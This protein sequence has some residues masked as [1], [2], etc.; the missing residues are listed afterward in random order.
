MKKNM[1][2]PDRIIRI[3]LATIAPI[4]YVTDVISGTFAIVFLIITGVLLVT[5]LSKF[6]PL[7]FPFG[8]NTDK[9]SKQ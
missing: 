5:S 6:C 3:I 4:L 2:V 7:Y 1:G 9:N 8:I